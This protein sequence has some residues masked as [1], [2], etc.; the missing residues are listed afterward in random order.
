MERADASLEEFLGTIPIFGGLEPGAL[1][2]VRGM[3]AELHLSPGQRVCEQGE[4]GRVMYIVR[5]GEVL[6]SRSGPSGGRVRMV[7]LGPGEFFGEMTLI[8]PQP[9][10]ATVTVERPTTL[11]SLTGK[12]LYTLYQEDLAGYAMVLQNLCRELA[13]RLRYADERI[14]QLVTQGEEEEHTQLTFPHAQRRA[15]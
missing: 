8:D 13:R 1:A 5:E 7:R 10:S 3:L 9:R 4:H 12:D 15:P 2:R 14:C 11:L 6:V